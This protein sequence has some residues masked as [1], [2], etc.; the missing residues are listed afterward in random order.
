MHPPHADTTHMYP[1]ALALCAHNAQVW[2]CSAE[3][4]KAHWKEGGH[5]NRC[6]ALK[7]GATTK[8][9]THAGSDGRACIICLEP[10]PPPIQ[11]GCACRGDAGLAHV[12][13]RILA[14]EHSQKASGN[15]HGW[16]NCST[17]NQIFSGAMGVGL[18]NEFLRQM[19]GD[20]DKMSDW[21]DAAMMLANA[22]STT[23]EYAEAESVCRE[24]M[25]SFDLMR[26][27]L[28]NTRMVDLRSVFGYALTNQCKYA[29]AHSVFTRCVA[30]Y[31][32]LVGPDAAQ[33]LD[34]SKCLGVVY[35]HLGKLAEGVVI[36]KDTFERA[37]LVLGRTDIA[38]LACG[39]ALAN[40]L[41]AQC[42]YGE[43]HALYEE[44][45][46]VAKRLLGPDHPLAL[47]AAG[48]HAGSVLNYERLV[49]KRQSAEQSKAEP[50]LSQRLKDLTRVVGAVV[51]AAVVYKTL[52]KCWRACR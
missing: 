6:K 11:S 17:C 14:A 1:T 50:M 7:A 20:P 49:E 36:L 9:C 23:G 3:C 22:L 21:A 24:T 15:A 43:S 44:L 39:L 4:Q 28:T 52:A 19:Q 29:E 10:D 34:C 18:A 40:A 35:G 48:L 51:V 32:V 47:E 27:S 37:K 31:T 45:E 2:Y 33:T 12:E 13:C 26:L 30:E 16:Q 25:L 46:P 38:S 8:T 41:D 5:K 42:K